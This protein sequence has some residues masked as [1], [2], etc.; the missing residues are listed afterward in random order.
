MFIWTCQS[1]DCISGRDAL[2]LGV[3]RVDEDGNSATGI[4]HVPENEEEA[5]CSSLDVALVRL[6][7]TFRI[8]HS[9][10]LYKLSRS[11]ATIHTDAVDPNNQTTSIERKWSRRWFVLRADACLYFFKTDKVRMINKSLN[12]SCVDFL[13]Y[14]VLKLE[15]GT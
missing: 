1:S 6:D 5:P 11:S 15:N 8:I 12:E 3:A 9:G 7:D 14:N 2:D 4:P 10:Y 13:P